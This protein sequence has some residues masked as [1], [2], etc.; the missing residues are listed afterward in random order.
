MKQ[1]AVTVL[2]LRLK[3][4]ENDVRF[5]TFSHDFWLN[6]QQMPLPTISITQGEEHVK[7]QNPNYPCCLHNV[8]VEC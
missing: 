2:C 5:G 7:L 8:Q 1:R 3:D 6:G 4:S